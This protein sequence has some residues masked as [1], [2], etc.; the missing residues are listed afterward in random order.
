LREN[1]AVFK[2]FDNLLIQPIPDLPVEGAALLDEE[3]PPDSES[4]ESE[5]VP[6]AGLHAKLFFAAKKGRRQL[7]VGSANATERGWEGRNYEAVAEL[8][9]GRDA[10][11]AIEGFVA[12][13]KRFIPNSTQPPSDEDEEAVEDARKLLCG[14]WSLIQRVGE[15]QVE[16]VATITPPLTD[17]AVQLEVAVLGGTWAPWPREEKSLVFSGLRPWQRSDFLQMRLSRGKRMCAWLQI[18]PC[19]P[20]ADEDRD[21][22]LI[23][24]YLDPRTFLLWL[25]SVLADEPARSGGGDWDSEPTPPHISGSNGR[26]ALDYGLMPTVE[27]VLRAW[28]NDASTF[29]SADEKVKAY[30]D[31]LERLALEANATSDVDLLRTFRR[32]WNT[33]ATELR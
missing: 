2:G 30:L 9:L 27:E 8:S 7:W 24:Q 4:A 11:D 28:A 33:L 13:C 22:A 23:A 16:V 25:R 19:D 29:L 3:P 12:D 6:P 21:R 14:H 1:E 5:E 31:E 26:G 32:T 20:A 15:T 18:A 17:P 10:A